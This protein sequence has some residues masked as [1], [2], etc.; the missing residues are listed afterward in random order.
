MAVDPDVPTRMAVDPGNELVQPGFPGKS[1]R[2]HV[3]SLLFLLAGCASRSLGPAQA[4]LTSIDDAA[5]V[6]AQLIA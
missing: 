1:N 2:S 4:P 6:G 3:I 5:A